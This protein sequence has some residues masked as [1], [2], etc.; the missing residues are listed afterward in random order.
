MKFLGSGSCHTRLAQKIINTVMYTCTCYD[1]F[2]LTPLSFVLALFN[3]Q[4]SSVMTALY[5]VSHAKSLTG[6]LVCKPFISHTPFT[7]W[8]CL[9]PEGSVHDS[10]TLTTSLTAQ[11]CRPPSVA[12]QQGTVMQ[13]AIQVRPLS[14]C[15]KTKTSSHTLL[16]RAHGSKGKS[17]T[18]NV[19][20]LRQ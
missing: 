17:A 13:A 16:V 4:H 6:W 15:T 19:R 9:P 2:C 20:C 10:S 18:C 7:H 3:Q 8:Q 5:A 14:L 11:E 1:L 12:V